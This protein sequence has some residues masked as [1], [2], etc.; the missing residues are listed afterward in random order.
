[1][2]NLKTKLKKHDKKK[3][4]KPSTKEELELLIAGDKDEETAKDFHMRDLVSIDNNKLKKLRGPGKKK[5]S[6]IWEN[7][8]GMEFKLDNKDDCFAAILEGSD[9]WFAWN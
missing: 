8:S 1:M 9:D 3:K 2:K 6:D 4:K 7:A 5:E